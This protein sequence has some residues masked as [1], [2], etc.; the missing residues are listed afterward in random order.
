MEDGPVNW[1]APPAD[2]N[3]LWLNRS[4]EILI[5][6]V[7]NW[8][9]VSCNAFSQFSSFGFV[10]RG[11][12]TLDQI[13]HFCK[14]MRTSN[15]YFGRI[16]ILGGEP[17]LHKDF[18]EIVRV[19][20]GLVEDGHVGH[21]EVITNGTHQDRI[22]P[23]AHLIEKVKVSGEGAKEKHHVANLVHT[24]K[25]LGY[26][27]K[28]CNQPEHCGWTL[29]AYGFSACSSAAGIQRLRDMMGPEHQKLEL[30]QVRGTNANW[31][32]LQDMCD[33]CFCGLRPEDKIRS[34]TRDAS[35]NVPGPDV[36]GDVAAWGAGKQPDWPIYGQS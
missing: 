17:T 19:L 22:K 25:S 21:L 24:P 9:C 10:K 28:R 2:S 1:K 23:I 32:K 30:P 6:L 13:H 20:H 35:K 29:S 12:M 27:G 14:E 16:R 33:L 3:K 8:T 34:G 31:P 15:A 7:C 11:T 36:A 18:H 5:T 26:S 4:L